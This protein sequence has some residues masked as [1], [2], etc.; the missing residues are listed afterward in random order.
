MRV[1]PEDTTNAE[2]DLQ[3]YINGT[4]PS[5]VNEHRLMCKDGSYKWVLSRCI[6]TV[7]EGDGVATRLIGTHTDITQQKSLEHALLNSEAELTNQPRQRVQTRQAD[8]QATSSLLATANHALRQPLTA[9]SLYVEVL[10]K[11]SSEDVGLGVKIHECVSSLTEMLDNLLNV[12]KLNDD[13]TELA[14]SSF[15]INNGVKRVVNPNLFKRESGDHEKPTYKR[16]LLDRSCQ[17][18]HENQHLPITLSDIERVSCMSK[19]SL[20][21]AF[22]H[23]FKCTPMQWVRTQ[24][25]ETAR[26]M[27]L[28]VGSTL[29][30]T[31]TAF[32]C[33]FNKSST[34]SHYYNQHFGEYPS[35]TISLN[36]AAR[37]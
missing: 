3:S 23:N 32:L 18:I 31:A 10:T 2:S 8:R 24:R 9:L 25:L 7:H 35:T 6:I 22:Q 16:R 30:V 36:Y 27:L 12:S 26:S 17:F 29:T 20:H 4:K 15:I 1:H 13:I 11:K 14:E 5:F 19:R 28:K 34:F 21:Y 37:T 33:G